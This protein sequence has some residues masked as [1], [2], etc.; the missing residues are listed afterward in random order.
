M[1]TKGIRASPSTIMFDDPDDK[2]TVLHCIM[3]GRVFL[4]INVT[5]PSTGKLTLNALTFG[6]NI[7]TLRQAF[8]R[9]IW[10]VSAI[11]LD[12]RSQTGDLNRERG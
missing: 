4:Q 6:V 2:S 11:K 12:G 9:Q 3:R 7:S 5:S 10:P 1:K 8:D